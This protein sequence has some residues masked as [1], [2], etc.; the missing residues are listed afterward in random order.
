[1]K[2]YCVLEPPRL[3]GDIAAHA[4]R[5]I[6]VRDSFSFTAFAF[7]ALWMLWHR[8][9]LVFFV[10]ICIVAALA[11]ALFA[12]GASTFMQG[13]VWLLLHLLVGFEGPSLRRMTLMHRGW[14][15]LGI[16]VADDIEAAERRFFS[17]WVPK[18]HDQNQIPLASTPRLRV[19][20]GDDV[21]GLFP[22]PGA[23][24]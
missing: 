18:A 23:N 10:Y 22:K 4:Q 19:P 11:T 1:M 13:L 21:I 8:M 14:H 15:D 12:L 9:W 20:Q 16:V 24:R 7:T 2:A 3:G 6:F 5:F 17:S